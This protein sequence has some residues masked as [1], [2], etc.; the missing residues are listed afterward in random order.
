MTWVKNRSTWLSQ[1][2]QVGVNCMW[3]RGR[4]GTISPNNQRQLSASTTNPD[5]VGPGAGAG[6]C[7]GFSPRGPARGEAG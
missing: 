1:E 7:R 5:R 6:R 3:N 4:D 2:E